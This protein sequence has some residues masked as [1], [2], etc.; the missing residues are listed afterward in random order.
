MQSRLLVPAFLA[1]STLAAPALAQD[2]P[3]ASAAPAAG[4]M[5]PEQINA[6]N[7]AV[8]DFT[9]GQTALPNLFICNTIGWDWL[10]IC[11]SILLFCA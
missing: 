8:T 10:V 2:A 9:A 7:Q 1:L 5:T 3:A 6:F 4:Q 11:Y